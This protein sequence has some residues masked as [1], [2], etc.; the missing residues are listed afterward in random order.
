MSTAEAPARHVAPAAPT[1]VETD[2]VALWASS[3]VT[4]LGVAD[5]P[6]YG[7]PAWSA[8]HATDPRRAVAIITAA[9]QWRR[10]ATREAWLA[11]LLDEDPER[12]FAYVTADANDYARSIVGGLAR[13]PTQ[14]E[15]RARRAVRARPHTVTATPGWPPIAIPGR[16]GWVRTLPRNGRQVDRPRLLQEP[17]RD[18]ARHPR[19]PNGGCINT[20]A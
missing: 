2:A 1:E 9:E 4:A 12:W 5:A 17:S 11:Q 6:D 15:L 10:R 7:S 13:R 3:Q 19:L 14:D 18:P 20:A 16:P 8:L